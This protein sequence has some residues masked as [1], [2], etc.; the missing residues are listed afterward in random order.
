MTIHGIIAIAT[1]VAVFLT[2]QLRRRT[3]TDLVFLGG[4]IIVVVTGVI[5]PTQAFAGF[6]RN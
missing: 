2:V 4:L 3:P 1:A 6:L 5:S